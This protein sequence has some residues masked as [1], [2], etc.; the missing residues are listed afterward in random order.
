MKVLN[1]VCSH[2][3]KHCKEPIVVIHKRSNDHLIIPE[4][5]ISVVSKVLISATF[6]KINENEEGELNNHLVI[7]DDTNVE[8]QGESF[9]EDCHK[10]CKTAVWITHDTDNPII[11]ITL[12]TFIE[13]IKGFCENNN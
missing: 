8:S 2:C 5:I 10:K 11:H 13:T 12:N 3:D 1:Y 9:C 4:Q 6:E 7:D